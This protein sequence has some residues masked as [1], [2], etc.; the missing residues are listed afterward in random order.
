M[1][2]DNGEVER[3]WFRYIFFGRRSCCSSAEDE[4]CLMEGPFGCSTQTV[5][6]LTL[7]I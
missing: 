7:P 5:G 3:I 6:D 4:R 1:P 2:S